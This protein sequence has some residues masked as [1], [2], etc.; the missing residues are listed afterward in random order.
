MKTKSFFN[1]C[2]IMACIILGYSSCGSQ[3]GT[4]RII[5][6]GMMEGFPLM[7]VNASD[8]CGNWMIGYFNDGFGGKTTHPF[9]RCVVPYESTCKLLKGDGTE[10]TDSDLSPLFMRFYVSGGNLF[11]DIFGKFI[12]SSLNSE[13]FS[14]IPIKLMVDGDPEPPIIYA[15]KSSEDYDRIF[16]PERSNLL[17]FINYMLNNEN[18]VMILKGKAS[19]YWNDKYDKL[20]SVDI[21]TAGFKEVYSRFVALQ[22]EWE[23]SRKQE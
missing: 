9:I 22:I 20:Y 16:I 17:T 13:V 18:V 11:L 21:N 1:T 2:L 23:K 15:D 14:D 4:N 5:K 12:Q 6:S 3:G 19:G 10:P 7:K 8:S